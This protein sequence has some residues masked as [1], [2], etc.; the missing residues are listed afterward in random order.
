MASK[1]IYSIIWVFDNQVFNEDAFD[2]LE[3]L[4]EFFGFTDEVVE[5]LQDAEEYSDG[6]GNV[7]RIIKEIEYHTKG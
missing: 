5:G 7:Y 6:E 3:E 4:Q 1:T 2:T